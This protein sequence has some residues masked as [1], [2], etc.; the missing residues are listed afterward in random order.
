MTAL[1]SVSTIAKSR[2]ARHALRAGVSLAGQAASRYAKQK[3]KS[4]LSKGVTETQPLTYQHDNI[5]TYKRRRPNPK[6]L[7][8]KLKFAKK[9]TNIVLNTQRAQ[10]FRRQNYERIVAP[11]DQ[12]QHGVYL[13]K[14]WDGT[15]GLQDDLADM[16]TQVATLMGS[17]NITGE[18]FRD[19]QWVVQSSGLD[20]IMTAVTA[21]IVDVYEFSCRKDLVEASA[22]S[23]FSMSPSLINGSTGINATNLELSPFNSKDFVD[24]F[25]INEKR[26]YVL[27]AGQTV[28]TNLKDHRNTSLSGEEFQIAAASAQNKLC[29]KKGVT[30][31]YLVVVSG[32]VG[33]GVRATA[34]VDI[35]ATRLYRVK[36]LNTQPATNQQIL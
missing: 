29:A 4:A 26:R 33:N 22:W 31:G 25:V 3:I 32:T 28:A 13:L 15:N 8:R 7:K 5:K 2:A 16:N 1:R 18:T 17:V 19:V 9:V 35:E 34:T 24:H 36:V 21:A 12:Q 30:S 14:S 6:K 27:S 20:F 11:Q 23:A 10:T